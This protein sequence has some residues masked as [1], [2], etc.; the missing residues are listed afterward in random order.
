M[1]L[2]KKL[3][4]H[5]VY[6]FIAIYLKKKRNYSY[7]GFEL[8]IL[9]GVFHPKFFFSSKVL[10]K[11]IQS[12]T[13]K[14]TTC[15]EIGCGSGLLSM[16]MSRMGAKVTAT[17]IQPSALECAR[18]NFQKNGQQFN[19]TPILKKSNLF[20]SLKNER[21]DTIFINP[22][23]FFAPITN[24]SELPWYCGEHGEYFERL[25]SEISNH[26]NPQGRVYM[27]LADTCDIKRIEKIALKNGLTL[28]LKLSKKIWWEYNYIMQIES[29]RA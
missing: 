8:C 26:T 24:D 9:P 20:D 6:P 1:V 25:F 14:N 10:Y 7:D 19:F 4:I 13:L 17:D 15:L 11:F 5:F 2:L 27:I 23:Y 3:Y 29:I 18:L 21:Y 12:N 28:N 22:P 16:L